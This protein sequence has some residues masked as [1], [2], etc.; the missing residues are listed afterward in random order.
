MKKCSSGCVPTRVPT[1]S[2]QNFNI[3]NILYI[4]CRLEVE[5]GGFSNDTERHFDVSS[6]DYTSATQGREMTR[7]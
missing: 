7:I 1:L 3:L 6:P 4:L 2:Q 5:P